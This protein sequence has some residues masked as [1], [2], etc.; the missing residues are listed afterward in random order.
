MIPLI[1]F[2]VLLF[3]L[4]RRILRKGQ[5]IDMQLKPYRY[6]IETRRSIWSNRLGF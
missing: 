2:S 1:I 6:Q 3:L 4:A 5:V